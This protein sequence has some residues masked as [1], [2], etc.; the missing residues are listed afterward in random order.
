LE[1]GVLTID[2]ELT[3]GDW[4]PEADDGASMKVDAFAEK[5]RSPQIPG[6]MIRV[7]QGTEILATFHNLLPTVAVIHGM[8]RHPG[9]A[10]DT[11][12]VPPGETVA[13]RFLAGEAGTYQYFA[14]AGGS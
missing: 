14:S 10:A 12:Q 1:G 3:P 11:L 8:H 13:V 4:Y 7:P 2:L 9:D 5:G 6:P